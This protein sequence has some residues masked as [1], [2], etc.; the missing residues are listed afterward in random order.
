MLST[1]RFTNPDSTLSKNSH[2]GN[3]PQAATV[4]MIRLGNDRYMYT[5]DTNIHTQYNNSYT[6]TCVRIYIRVFICTV[7][8]HTY[9]AAS[10][11]ECKVRHVVGRTVAPLDRSAALYDHGCEGERG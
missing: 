4:T 7:H 10:E 1:G 2:G 3:S 5:H 8:T 11:W 6:C 9:E